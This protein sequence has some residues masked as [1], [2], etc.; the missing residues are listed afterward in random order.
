MSLQITRL[1][2]KKNQNIPLKMLCATNFTW[3]TIMQIVTIVHVS[4]PTCVIRGGRGRKEAKTCEQE[5]TRSTLRLVGRGFGSVTR[6]PHKQRQHT[7]GRGSST[8]HATSCPGTQHKY[9]RK[10]KKR[11]GNGTG[12]SWEGE[13]T[14]IYTPLS[15]AIAVGVASALPINRLGPS[16]TVVATLTR[17]HVTNYRRKKSTL[18]SCSRLFMARFY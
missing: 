3:A 10:T 6:G 17:F 1:A 4:W 18:R 7:S 12:G 16:D 9:N 14:N 2:G 13:G 11:K 8:G 15:R 5:T